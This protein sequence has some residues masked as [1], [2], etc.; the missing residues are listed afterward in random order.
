MALAGDD[1][2][3][4]RDAEGADGVAG[5]VV[6]PDEGFHLALPQGVAEGFLTEG[7]RS[8]H[9]AVG[10]TVVE[11]VAAREPRRGGLWLGQEH[12]VHGACLHHVQPHEHVVHLY[13]EH[14]L[15]L[16]L[17]AVNE[18]VG[19]HCRGREARHRHHLVV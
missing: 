14:A 19:D 9:E 16:Q 6:C 10:G 4:V 3:V 7:Y 15:R 17:C 13:A 11:H 1:V 18:V 12:G 8:G 2:T 5:I